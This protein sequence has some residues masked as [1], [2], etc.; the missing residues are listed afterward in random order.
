MTCGFMGLA[1]LPIGIETRLQKRIRMGLPI[2][3]IFIWG[4]ILSDKRSAITFYGSPRVLPKNEISD[5][6][7]DDIRPQMKIL[8]IVIL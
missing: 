7:S 6:I 5:H 2:F 4:G 8:N 3:N 1:T